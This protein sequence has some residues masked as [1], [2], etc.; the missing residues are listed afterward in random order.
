MAGYLNPI[1]GE[2]KEKE[3]EAQ[4]DTLKST[5]MSAHEQVQSLKADSCCGP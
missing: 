5:L 2:Q 3:I 4:V 1:L